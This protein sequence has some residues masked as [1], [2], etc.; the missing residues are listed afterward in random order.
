MRYRNLTNI[1]LACCEPF[2]R[3]RKYATGV[4]AL[5]VA[6]PGCGPEVRFGAASFWRRDASV[7]CFM[8]AAP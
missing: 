8:D 5:V 6:R 1:T 3:L 4:A 7:A 2:G